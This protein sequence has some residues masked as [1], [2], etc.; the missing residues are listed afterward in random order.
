M[1]SYTTSAYDKLDFETPLLDQTEVDYDEEDDFSMREVSPCSDLDLDLTSWEEDDEQDDTLSSTYEDPAVSIIYVI[2][3]LSQFAMAGGMYQAHS[4]GFGCLVYFS[5][6][7]FLISAALYKDALGERSTKS[8]SMCI[9]L[10]EVMVNIIVAVIYFG[11]V[12]WGFF[13]LLACMIVLK[14]AVIGLTLQSLLCKKQTDN[15]K[16]S[17]PAQ[18]S[19]GPLVVQIV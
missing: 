4:T 13:A 1:S 12:E 7:L 11:Q 19:N 6:G 3:L 9:L 18:H 14:C 16:T 17:E 5:I 2:L 10:P 8:R 15:N